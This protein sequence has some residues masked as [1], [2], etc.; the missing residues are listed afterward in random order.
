[1]REIESVASRSERHTKRP[2]GQVSDQPF[3]QALYNLAFSRGFTPLDLTEAVKKS[4]GTVY[5]WYNGR[6]VPLPDTFGELLILLKPDDSELET[7]AEAYGCLLRKNKRLSRA[8]HPSS[9]PV[10]KWIEDICKERN[11]SIKQC[12]KSLGFS[13]TLQRN[14]LSLESLISLVQNAK[15]ALHLSEEETKSLQEAIVQEIQKR[16]EEGRKTYLESPK[17]M[18]TDKNESTT[19]YSGPLAARRLGISREWLRKLRKKFNLGAILTDSDI[20]KLENHLEKT[21]DIRYKI[22]EVRR[23]G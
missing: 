10:G 14:T 9:K 6:S 18:S 4:R 12:M 15:E 2:Y 17:T 8:I 21:R 5:H 16:S 13:S 20:E 19:I 1:M 22:Q 7:L 3:P 11:V 23:K